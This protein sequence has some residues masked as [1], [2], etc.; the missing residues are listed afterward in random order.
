MR[1]NEDNH[2][3]ISIGRIRRAVGLCG[4][5]G[6]FSVALFAAGIAGSL[7]TIQ[8]AFQALS[9]VLLSACV[10]N[11]NR[12]AIHVFLCDYLWLRPRKIAADPKATARRH[13]SA[14]VLADIVLTLIGAAGAVMLI[15]NPQVSLAWRILP[16]ATLSLAIYA[17]SLAT[18]DRVG[19]LNL[20]SGTKR[21]RDSSFGGFLYKIG[22]RGTR[23]PP[24]KFL[25]NLFDDPAP[26]LEPSTLAVLIAATL[27][28]FSVATVEIK[29]SFTAR[30]S[31]KTL[32]DRKEEKT[33]KDEGEAPGEAPGP[34]P[35]TVAIG[36]S[37]IELPGDVHIVVSKVDPKHPEKH[38]PL[39][40][41]DLP[42]I[43]AALS[44]I[45][46]LRQLT[47]PGGKREGD[48]VHVTLAG[49]AMSYE[50]F[51]E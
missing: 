30:E 37:E 14:L 34:G 23:F 2:D 4:G 49:K 11:F 28:F 51:D 21:V 32:F 42:F 26:P 40:R 5:T 46:R 3:Q 29:L 31:V 41:S 9:I 45:M 22:H 10:V 48:T 20:Q 8:G 24:V 50:W 15:E 44:V 27:L 47:W 39:A 19:L 17:V 36:G 18:A 43:F 38:L 33:H 13:L 16:T 35:N 12:I 25:I 1:G 7:L 6:N